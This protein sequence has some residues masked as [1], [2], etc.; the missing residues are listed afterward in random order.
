MS[1]TSGQRQA[2]APS[3]PAWLRM[4]LADAAP[5]TSISPAHGAWTSGLTPKS[6][7][8]AP[9]E[10][11]APRSSAFASGKLH[12]KWHVRPETG[13]PCPLPARSD[14]RSSHHADHG[15]NGSRRARP[16][17]PRG[18]RTRCPRRHGWATSPVLSRAA[19][20]SRFG[21][22]VARN[23]IRGAGG[24]CERHAGPGRRPG[25]MACGLPVPDLNRGVAQLF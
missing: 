7:R 23:G 24:Y 20:A 3:L 16:P 22:P 2:E 10:P 18:G 8:H 21:K 17:G 19:P 11:H 13:R 14:A 12:I 5:R 4:S 6:R 15:R 25:A 9:I 1:T